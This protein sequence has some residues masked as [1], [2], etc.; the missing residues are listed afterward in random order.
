[1]S[2]TVGIIGGMGPLATV[3]MLRKIIFHSPAHNDQEHLHIIVD[4]FPQIPDRTAAILGQ[5]KDPIPLM[6]QSA[7]LLEDDGAELLVMA[8]NT[9]HYYW[10]DI[11]SLIKTPMLNIQVETARFLRELH[12]HKVGLLAT[13][14][15][16]KSNLYQKACQKEEI[17]ILEPNAEAQKSV[18]KGI[19]EIKAGNLETGKRYLSEI[20]HALVTEGAEAIIAGCTEIPLIL[21]STENLKVIDPTEILAEA[22][23]QRAYSGVIDPIK[24]TQRVEGF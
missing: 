12:L 24:I 9:A 5:G 4:D 10:E 6:I 20:A 11:V 15:T 2:K 7:K 8:C 17:T 23:V 21:H 19:Y 16:L 22:V 14:G 1:M 3:D 13:D 18:M